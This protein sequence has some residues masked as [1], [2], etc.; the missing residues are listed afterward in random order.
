MAQYSYDL[1]TQWHGVR[2]VNGESP[3]KVLKELSRFLKDEEVYPVSINFSSSV[4]PDKKD[5]ILYEAN[6]VYAR[7]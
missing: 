3:R 1:N 2:H 4:H 5:E 6:L 7:L